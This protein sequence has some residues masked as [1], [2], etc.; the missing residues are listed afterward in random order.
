ME[1]TYE[2]VTVKNFESLRVPKYVQL[3]LRLRDQ[4]ETG[5][6]KHGDPL[7]TREKLMKEYGLS[8]STVTRAISELE[9]QGWLISRQ[10][11]GTFV[12]KRTEQG[13]ENHS[14]IATI[15]MV[16][17]FSRPDIQQ[18]VTEFAQESSEQNLN[19]MVMY[20]SDDEE[21]ELNQGRILLEKGVNSV[22]WFPVEP[23]RHVSVASLFRKNRIPVVICEKVAEQFDSPWLCIRSDY[24]GGTKSALQHFFHQGHQR[25][26]YI[27]P[28]GTE[29]DF[30]PINERWNAYKDFMKEHDL[31]NPDD[32]VFQPSLFKEWPVHVTRLENQFQRPK[33]PTAIVAYDDT[34]ALE[35][36]R[37]LQS[38]GLR[39][40]EDVAIIGH[41]D[42]SHSHYCNPRLSTVS[43][44][45][46]EFVD[47]LMTTLRKE[48]D[49]KPE[50]GSPLTSREIVIPQQLIL[51]ESTV[52]ANEAV[53]VN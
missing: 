52:Q 39:I 49:A 37:G 11:S 26:A 41:G 1:K 24:Y 36:V 27:G 20:T 34:L 30:G 18:F 6:L 19:V 43:I 45:W 13:V 46:S 8:L 53:A 3:M 25:I 42:C 22:V 10:G 12:V 17:P 44:C 15:G 2:V 9:R 23:K 32:L 31:W 4:I 5:V 50:E 21:F 38:I 40:P 35:A 33:A 51:R 29:S 7:P 28:K 48:L 14:E 47:T 16:V